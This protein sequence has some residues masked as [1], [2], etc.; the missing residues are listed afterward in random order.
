VFRVEL[1][2]EWLTLMNATGDRVAEIAVTAVGPDG[3]QAAAATSG[4]LAP[5]EEITIPLSAFSPRPTWPP[6][7]ILVSADA[8][9]GRRAFPVSP[10]LRAE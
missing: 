10:L 5:G 1:D 9:G 2:V 4:V 8:P 6:R 7:D 3:A